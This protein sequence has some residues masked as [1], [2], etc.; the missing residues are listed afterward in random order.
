LF[1]GPKLAPELAN[2]AK[3]RCCYVVIADNAR[4]LQGPIEMK[5][6][7]SPNLHTVVI[8]GSGPPILALL[9]FASASGV[10]QCLSRQNLLPRPRR[11]RKRLSPKPRKKTARSASAAARRV[12]P[13]T[14]TRCSS[15]CTRTPA[16]RPRP[17]AS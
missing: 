15:R 17:W 1:I 7:W 8:K 14:C 12:T 11:A 6:F 2:E 3:S 10:S 9:F 13:S 5:G 4:F 16:S